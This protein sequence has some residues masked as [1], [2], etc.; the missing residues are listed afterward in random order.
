[1]P[2]GRRELEGRLRAMLETAYSGEVELDLL[3]VRD[4]EMAVCNKTYM[5]C[6]GP[7]NILSFPLEEPPSDSDPVARLGSLVL[8]V[9]VLRREARLY[10]QN[11][12]EHCLRL[13][14]HGLGHLSGFDHGPE[15]DAFCAA[16]EAGIPFRTMRASGMAM[17]WNVLFLH[18]LFRQQDSKGFPP[19]AFPAGLW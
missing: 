18:P 12:E 13:L 4:G 17:L 8:S 9:D 2:L 3:L 14:A 7:T 1:M 10:G 19:L 16:M 15:M 6:P 5:N 11:P